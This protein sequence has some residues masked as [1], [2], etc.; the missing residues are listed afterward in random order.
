MSA[1][2]EPWRPIRVKLTPEQ[3]E[4]RRRQAE[5]ALGRP[6]PPLPTPTGRRDS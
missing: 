3:L 4:K 1:L 6:L 2:N 5:E